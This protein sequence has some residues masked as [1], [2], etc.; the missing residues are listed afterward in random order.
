MRAVNKKLSFL[1]VLVLL[2]NLL[3]PGMCFAAEANSAVPSELINSSEQTLLSPDT[4]QWGNQTGTPQ[5]SG[6][7]SSQVNNKEEEVADQLLEELTK[8]SSETGQV[9]A[10]FYPALFVFATVL[11]RVGSRYAPAIQRV[12]A[13]PITKAG[14]RGSLI[15]LT[16]GDP[17]KL[18]EAHHVFPQASRFT[19]MFMRAGIRI[20]DGKNLTWV[21][22]KYHRQFSYEYTK[23]WIGYQQWC[24][25]HGILKPSKSQLEYFAKQLAK[26]YKFKT[27]F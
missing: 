22:S 14:Y 1:L 8:S 11:V 25:N 15:K 7:A 18:Y 5:L 19:T 21:S 23:K 16:G 6:N 13:S 17:G 12:A 9:D 20:N 2:A 24:T 26:E 4:S 10:Q 3:L 27:Y